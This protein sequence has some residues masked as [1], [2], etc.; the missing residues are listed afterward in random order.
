[1]CCPTA[2]GLCNLLQPAHTNSSL[3]PP[4]QAQSLTPLI[5]PCPSSWALLT[6]PDTQLLCSSR[7]AA[8][9]NSFIL[10]NHFNPHPSVLSIQS[11]PKRAQHPSH[12]TTYYV[13]V[14]I[15][16]V[17]VCIWYAYNFIYNRVPRRYSPPK[18]EIT[19]MNDLQTVRGGDSTMI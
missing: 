8:A 7:W 6:C 13:G 12:S 4:V 19:I 9:S 16:Y 10:I 1:M 18:T 14:C 15:H 3:V 17:C 11:T 2:Q 5:T